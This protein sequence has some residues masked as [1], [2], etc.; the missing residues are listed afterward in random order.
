MHCVLSRTFEARTL[1][2]AVERISNPS[3]T[4]FFNLNRMILVRI[5][6]FLLLHNGFA[7][8][9]QALPCCANFANET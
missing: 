3:F 1:R 4:V 6:P 2:S 8:R 5:I 9:L 7:K